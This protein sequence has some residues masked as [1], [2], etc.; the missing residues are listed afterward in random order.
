[1]NIK[2]KWSWFNFCFENLILW[3]HHGKGVAITELCNWWRYIYFGLLVYAFCWLVMEL[4]L[5]PPI[6]LPEIFNH[7]QESSLTGLPTTFNLLKT[8]WMVNLLNL[9]FI[10]LLFFQFYT[11]IDFVLCS[12]NLACCNWHMAV[13]EIQILMVCFHIFFMLCWFSY[14]FS[15]LVPRFQGLVDWSF[16]SHKNLMYYQIFSKKTWDITN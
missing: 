16:S 8:G 12:C 7:F 10:S 13:V 5:K 4:K 1:M 11:C 2:T 9:L 3:H 15:F 6:N 14:P